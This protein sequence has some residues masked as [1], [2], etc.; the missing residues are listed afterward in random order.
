MQIDSYGRHGLADSVGLVMSKDRQ[1]SLLRTS[2]SGYAQE[3]VASKA[4]RPKQ[5]DRIVRD[6][7]GASERSGRWVMAFELFAGITKLVISWS[8]TVLLK[9]LAQLGIRYRPR[10]L[11]WLVRRPKSDDEG[12]NWYVYLYFFIA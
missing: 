1:T 11:L 10:W 3:K 8:A 7:V 2:T 4:G 12:E 6:G 9:F 5:T